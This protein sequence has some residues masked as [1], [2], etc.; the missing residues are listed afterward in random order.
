MS[1]NDKGVERM[2]PKLLAATRL[3]SQA[4]SA[5]KIAGVISPEKT[6]STTYRALAAR[7]IRGVEDA[8]VVPDGSPP[9]DDLMASPTTIDLTS[10]RINRPQGYD[11]DYLRTAS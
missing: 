9:V 2:S 7:D 10:R 6:R 5:L 4:N 11:D 8:T 3:Q 1:T